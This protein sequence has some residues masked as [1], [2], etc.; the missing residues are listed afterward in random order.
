MH[1][2]G[3][4][5]RTASMRN[6]LTKLLVIA[7]LVVVAGKGALAQTDDLATL[8]KRINEFY[9]AG[10]FSE[11]IPLAESALELTRAQNGEDHLVTAE[12]MSWLGLL[13]K[14]QGRLTDA[15]NQYL[16]SLAIREKK[17]GPDHPVV[18]GA[19]NN[20]ALLYVS[21]GRYAEAE[22]FFN[23]ALA[24]RERALGREHADVGTTLDGL[25]GLYLK[26]GRFA[27]AEPLLRRVLA[28]RETVLGEEHPA[29][30][31][32]LNSLAGLHQRQG[33][34]SEA[35]R[36]FKRS[37]AIAE[38]TLGPSHPE[39]GMALN[40]LAEL[41]VDQGRYAEAEPLF[42]R[43][44]ELREATLGPDHPD[45]GGSLN[46]LARLY[47]LRGRFAEAEPLYKR[48]LALREKALGPDHTDVGTTLN[49]LGGLYVRQRRY[50]EAEH[51][52]KRSLAIYERALGSDH[53]WVAA[54]LNSLAAVHRY[55]GQSAEAESLLNRSLALLERALAP[56]HPDVGRTLST[57][58]AV[59]FDRRD[60]AR[61]ADYW[62]RGADLAVRRMLR[63][64]V[65]GGVAPS[66]T[67]KSETDQFAAGF[68][69]LVKAVYRL[70]INQ[71]NPSSPLP[72]EAFQVAQWARGSQAAASLAQ[73]A[74]RGA[75]DDPGL[76]AIVR[77][78]QDLVAEWHRRDQYHTTAVSQAPDKR[79]REAEAANAQRLTTIDAR[80]GDIDARLTAEFPDYASLA[81]PQPLKIE[82]AQAELTPDEALVLFLDTPKWD[83]TPEETFVWIV[84]KSEVRWLRSNLGT[85]AL[86]R[87]VTALR[88]G[89]DAAAW[90]DQGAARCAGVLKIGQD[91]LPSPGAAL[92]F[93]ASRAHALYK[94]LFGEAQDLIKGKHLLIV[95][96]GPLT[97]LPFQVLITQPPTSSD[98]S[99]A[100]W[101]IREHAVTVL[102]SVASLATLRRT[103]RRSAATKPMV[104]FGNP[105]LDGNQQHPEL[106][107]D[108][109]QL[110]GLARAQT[111]CATT[112]PLRTVAL[113]AVSRGLLPVPQS[114]GLADLAHLKMQTP[115]P[116][117]AD[118]L[119]AVARSVGADMSEIRI[120]ARATETEI[121]RL[122]RAGELAGY[123]M[124]HFA[125]HGTLAGEISG[126][127]EPGLILT[128][129]AAASE[130][131]DGYLS[132]GEIAALKLDAE[133]VILSACNTAGGAGQGA[134]AEALSGLAR[135][136]FYAGAR[137]LLVS[138]W[139]VDSAATVTL[140][141]AAIAELTKNPPLGRAEALRRAMLTVV[142]DTSRPTQWVP[143]SH[144]SVWAPFVV[145]GEG[146][147]GR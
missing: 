98:L 139:E 66:G 30:A 121:K 132:A 52:F 122:S 14:Y 77:E 109:K 90:H 56:D 145:V 83:P 7:V 34:F 92:P 62:R 67:G 112:A 144:P 99:S 46:P 6:W 93:D 23:R 5:M 88:C 72:R 135:V 64:T 18:G 111:G 51:V 35:E 38:K 131:D 58:A 15:E 13:L 85:P 41:Y 84:T 44:L 78:R 59:H 69:G 91:N 138:H 17:L 71:Q 45:V 40:N 100:A 119:C 29:V 129:P 53:P 97:T 3:Q 80:L 125:T 76:V 95:S 21:Q 140:I 48:S 27:A 137:A 75:R 55:Q 39:V 141:T 87:E 128:P 73:M 8:N 108:F 143:A 10:K 142:A 36:M 33:Y 79:N 42:K 104:G 133:W 89:L 130:E 57:I 19:L 54:S 82:Q 96:S 105:L 123:R 106:A 60:W 124:L 63:G 31:V 74:A 9:R 117:T 118:E 115:L 103:A 2:G 107:A 50:A 61:A 47:M 120:G 4:Q 127:H 24:L 114:A 101:L 28:L 20:L 49:Y 43:S 26:Q 102:P 11:A 12:Q 22:S 68:V 37:L 146:G 136:F 94:S 81:S 25:A 1:L 134:A 147:A 86:T 70:E 16:R 116:E 110:A 113:R 126:T 32:T 65:V